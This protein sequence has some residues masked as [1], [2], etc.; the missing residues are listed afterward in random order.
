MSDLNSTLRRAMHCSFSYKN[1]MYIIGGYTFSAPA[2]SF[3]SRFNLETHKWE[4]HLDRKTSTVINRS[5][6]KFF[7]NSN[8]KQPKLD[9][10]QQRYAHTCSIDPKNVFK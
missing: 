6:R 2:L 3:V 8:F 5:N 9:L 7:S 10:P 4:H 1:F